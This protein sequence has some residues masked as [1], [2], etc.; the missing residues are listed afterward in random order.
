MSGV[1]DLALSD[2]LFFCPPEQ[3]NGGTHF[4]INESKVWD[5]YNFGS[6]I[7]KLL[8]GE[9]C[10]LN[11]EIL[12]FKKRNQNT[13]FLHSGITPNQVARA[14]RKRPNIKWPTESESKDEEKFRENYVFKG[15]CQIKK[16]L[17]FI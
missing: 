8:T 3:L 16:K 5:I 10:R 12:N 4:K 14:I 7:Y 15:F 6:T 13:D 9:F 2:S 1:E 11:E 17:N